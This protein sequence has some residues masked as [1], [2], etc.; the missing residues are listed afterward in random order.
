MRH[1]EAQ[2]RAPSGRDEDREL[3]AEG[4]ARA[5]AVARGLAALEPSIGAILTSPFRRAQQTADAAARALGVDS[6]R[7]FPELSPG[8]D[9][10]RTAA[11]LARGDWKSVLLVGHQPLLGAL[12]GLFAFGDQRRE[13]PLRKAAVAHVAWEPENGGRLEAFLP[14]RILERL[15]KQRP[16]S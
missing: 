10:G 14:P 13:F 1:G 7:E 12:I 5:E 2:D 3:T 16:G 11:A 9:P 4:L 8:A 15:G 6:P